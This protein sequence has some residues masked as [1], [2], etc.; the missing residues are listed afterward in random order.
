MILI[1]ILNGPQYIVLYE[2]LNM[3]YI[4]IKNRASTLKKFKTFYFSLMDSFFTLEL[5]QVS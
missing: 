4:K 3:Q 5:G 1:N 2:Y